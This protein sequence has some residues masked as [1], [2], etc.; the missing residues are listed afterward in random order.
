MSEGIDWD[1]TPSGRY[2]RT[3]SGMVYHPVDESQPDYLIVAKDLWVPL[4]AASPRD[5]NLLA[6][7]EREASLGSP[8]LGPVFGKVLLAV[9]VVGGAL[10]ATALLRRRK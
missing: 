1:N 9:G 10:G 7:Q 5:W 4:V 8:T 3:S 2:E 6:A